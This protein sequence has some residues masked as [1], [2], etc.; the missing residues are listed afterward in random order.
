M[1]CFAPYQLSAS[2]SLKNVLR[3]IIRKLS[4]VANVDIIK[5][6]KFQA[7]LVQQVLISASF[8]RRRTGRDVLKCFKTLSEKKRSKVGPKKEF[9]KIR[10]SSLLH[11]KLALP[12][13]PQLVV[14]LKEKS[15]VI[16]QCEAL[17]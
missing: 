10:F 15:V 7:H 1:P 5:S 9:L 16:H 11:I 2:V 13:A 17:E 14:F 6:D 12:Q 3:G 8:A 4:Q